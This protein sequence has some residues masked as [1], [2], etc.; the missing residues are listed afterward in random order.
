MKAIFPITLLA[1]LIS[2]STFA[3]SYSAPQPL[4]APSEF[5]GV[6]GLAVDH[7]DRLLAGSVVGNSIY[8]VSPESGEVSTVIGPDHGQADD[9]AIG[10]NGEMAWTG[11]YSGQVLYREND[12]APIRVLAEGK[13][14]I[15]SIAFNQQTGKL[16]ASQV[17]LGDA[18]WEIDVKGESEPRLIKK[19]MGGFNGFEV[20]KDGW[21]YGP[22]W[23]KGEVVK[24]NPVDGE[25]ETVADGF[26]TPA[27]VNF[28]SKGNLYVVDTLSG[29]LM[30]VD[31]A[32]GDTELVA[33]LD[34]AL[35]NLAIDAQD[36]IYVSNM[37]DNGISQ[38]NPS[39]GDVRVIT[40]GELAVPGGI[41]LAE[42]GKTLYVSDVFAFRSVDTATGEV[43]D[44]RR[45]HGSD[46]EYPIAVGLGKTRL[47]L[48]SFSTGTLHVI[49]RDGHSTIRIIHGLNAPSDAIELPDG[50]IVVSELASGSLAQLS[51]AELDNKRTLA[52]GLQ[53]P[54]Q[55]ILGQ[56]GK[57]YLTEAA[58]FLTRVD[59]ASGE[60][61][62]VAEGLLMPEGLAQ[63]ADGDFVIAESAAQRLIRL[64]VETGE[65][66]TLAENLPIGFPA[67]PG[68]P[69]SGIPTGVAVA[70]D[71]TV[72]FTSDVDNG[73]YKIEL[74]PAGN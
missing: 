41:A 73:L 70:A 30:R 26:G 71:G 32:T 12:D 27:A 24:I 74:E 35:D 55:M 67:G 13:P 33:E 38:V 31:I 18:L 47:L 49:D 50:S 42:D 54:V 16:F 69:P 19:D 4:V 68:M 17:F 20:G 44:I 25:M 59:P 21:V 14:G 61:K 53:G 8:Q 65:R 34:T 43:H 6:H 51:G 57:I 7:Q 29:Q 36:R 2:A 9:I 15:N 64:N 56:D 62:R 58:G 52:D 45:A 72:Y 1:S 46:V 40:Q 28:D 60:V 23:F 22:L 39:T 63:T 3:A 11:F 5:K 48:T 66:I 10:P 37:A